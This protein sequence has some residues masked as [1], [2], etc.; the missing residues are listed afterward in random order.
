MSTEGPPEL[1]ARADRIFCEAL[2]VRPR[3][4]ARFLDERCHGDP[5]LRKTVE[6]L[7]STADGLDDFLDG[8]MSGV[9]SEALAALAGEYEE[10]ARAAPGDHVGAYR[11]VVELGR[12]GMGTVYLGERADGAFEQTAAVKLLR[13]GP[14]GEE[15]RPRFLAERQILASL[16][17]PNIARLLDGGATAQ[18]RPY[19]IMEY[20]AGTPINDYCDEHRLDVRARLGLFLTVAE[21]VAHAHRKLVVHRD[22]KPGN[23]LVDRDGTVKLLDFGIAKLLEPGDDLRVG[24]SPETRPGA[25]LLTPEYAAPEQL[26]GESVTTATDVYALSALLYELLTGCRP[27]QDRTDLGSALERVVQGAVP[28]LPSAVTRYEPPVPPPRPSEAPGR[29]ATRATTREG[30]E[31]TLAGDL[32]A[33]LLQGLRSRP[34]DRYSSVEALREDLIRYLERRPVRARGDAWRYRARS[35]VRRHRLGVSLAAAFVALL[36]GSVAGLGLQQ[37]RVVAE[38]DRAALEAETSAQVTRFLTDLFNDTENTVGV[39]DTLTARALLARGAERLLDDQGLEPRVRARLL[40]TLGGVHQALGDWDGARGQYSRALEVE[41]ARE[42]VD[43]AGIRIALRNLASLELSAGD[44]TAS[45]DAARRA[46]QTEADATLEP[47]ALLLRIAGE[48]HMR[49]HALDS[50]EHYLTTALSLADAPTTG[51][52]P[53][54]LQVRLAMLYRRT[55]RLEEA[56]N[57]YEAL[58]QEIREEYDG[59]LASA[60]VLAAALNNLA[61]VRRQQGDL[62]AAAPLIEEALDVVSEALGARHPNSLQLAANLVGIW[63]GQGRLPEALE[64]HDALIED[65]LAVDPE[66]WGVGV[67]YRVETKLHL[68]SGDPAGAVEAATR[69]VEILSESLGPLHSWTAVSLGWFGAAALAAGDAERAELGFTNSLKTLSTYEGLPEDSQVIG[70]VSDLVD[71]LEESGRPGPAADYRAMLDAHGVT[72]LPQRDL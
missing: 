61:F 60:D 9:P 65:Q 40:G 21:A 55:G 19:L 56:S 57:V 41:R 5:E 54:G 66:S 14:L 28:T 2:D 39:A 31:E 25:R 22:L 45:I 35:Y 10:A 3:D 59:S 52:L 27:Y 72:E 63:T 58:V 15:F 51:D 8:P 11:L 34:E 38:R 43:P 29:F 12:G 48:A 18:G 6:S 46:L 49:A 68:L 42:P 70:F 53:R 50:A 20:V 67:R 13:P 32:D 37:R 44:F 71:H 23:I 24:A 36:L 16:D 1:W 33:I 17:H 62:D 64:L 4:R 7:L 47:D 69:S 26:L 30:L